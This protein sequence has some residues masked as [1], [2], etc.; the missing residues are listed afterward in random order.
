MGGKARAYKCVHTDAEVLAA[1]RDA[2]EP[3]QDP[4]TIKIL[5]VSLKRL[6][7]GQ[8][9]RSEALEQVLG[10]LEADGSA[11]RREDGWVTSEW[12]ARVDLDVERR[13]F[14]QTVPFCCARCG[15][16]TGTGYK[17]RLSAGTGWASLCENCEGDVFP[18]TNPIGHEVSVPLETNRRKH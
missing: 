7:G 12:R 13:S 18:D 3:R 1:L 14:P 9:S 6:Y 2:V 16:R 4:A 10:R 17:H 8:S 5:R 11:I 15:R